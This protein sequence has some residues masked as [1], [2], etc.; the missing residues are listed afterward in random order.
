MDEADRILNMD[1]EEEVD[2]LL[3]VYALNANFDVVNSHNCCTTRGICSYLSKN[4]AKNPTSIQIVRGGS[5]YF[6]KL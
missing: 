3:V 6:D 5:A 2:K 1:F 4:I